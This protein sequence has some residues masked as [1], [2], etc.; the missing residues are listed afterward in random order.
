[1]NIDT[2][3]MLRHVAG[4]IRQQALE[5][6]QTSLAVEGVKKAVGF[7]VSE[8]H[9]KGDVSLAT[10]ADYAAALRAAADAVERE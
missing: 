10:R 4:D 9:V 1:M 5:M 8:V 7:L 2:Y 3:T 6:S